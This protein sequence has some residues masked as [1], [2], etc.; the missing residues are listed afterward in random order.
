M[1]IPTTTNAT[2]TASYEA[3][4]YGLD[5]DHD[6]DYV[7]DDDVDYDD[8][9]DVDYRYDHNVDC[10]DDHDVDVTYPTHRDNF[11]R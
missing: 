2:M 3:D 7:D 8:G 9:H 5:D 10:D 1:L 4:D 11:P 6:V